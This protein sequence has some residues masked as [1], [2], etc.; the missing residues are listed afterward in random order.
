MHAS[1]ARTGI[2]TSNRSYGNLVLIFFLVLFYPSF[3]H[4]L[5]VTP[6]PVFMVRVSVK[7]MMFGL[8]GKEGKMISQMFL[9]SL[10]KSLP[11]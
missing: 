10:W 9:S 1:L 6:F 2:T 5:D 8:K 7:H 3:M 11:V 4:S